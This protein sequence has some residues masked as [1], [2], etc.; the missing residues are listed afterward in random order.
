MRRCEH[1]QHRGDRPRRRSTRLARRP[2]AAGP[3]RTGRRGRRG[4]GRLADGGGR[5][6]LAATSPSVF[7]YLTRG[8]GVVALVLLTASIVLG[9]VSTIRW[10]TSGLPRFAVAGLHRM[11]TLLAIVFVAVHVVTTVAD[12]F[13]PIGWTDAVV[14]FL[15]PYRPVWLGL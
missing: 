4:R 1:R 11:L 13:A 8:S 7:W 6:I 5:V 10:S 14:P 15:S 9:I 12:G 3:A 2:T